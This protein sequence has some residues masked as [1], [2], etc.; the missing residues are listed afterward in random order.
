MAVTPRRILFFGALVTALGLGLAAMSPVTS[1]GGAE[2]PPDR[3][4]A[5][6]VLVLV[7]WTFLAWGIHRFGRSAE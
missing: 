4:L 6:G 1:S 5:G 7:G 3:R 2:G